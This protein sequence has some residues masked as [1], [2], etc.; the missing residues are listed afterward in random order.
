MGNEWKEVQNLSDYTITKDACDEVKFEAV[1]TQ[2]IKLEVKLQKEYS[3]GVHE[4]EIK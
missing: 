3:S 2:A 1:S 4:W